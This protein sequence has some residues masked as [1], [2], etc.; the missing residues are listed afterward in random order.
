M[1]EVTISYRTTWLDMVPDW[2]IVEMF[3]MYVCENGQ[4]IIACRNLFATMHTE[5]T[6][7]RADA[8]FYLCFMNSTEVRW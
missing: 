1:T 8:A 2:K 5:W 7:E 4:D 6:S 3:L